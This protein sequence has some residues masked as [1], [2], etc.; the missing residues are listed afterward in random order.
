[1]GIE[2]R[3]HWLG[4]LRDWILDN[5]DRVLDTMQRETG[6]V[7]A[8]ATNEPAYLADLINF[9]GT[10][11]AEL[12]RRGG[13]PAALAAARLEEAAG[14]VPAAPGGRD[15]QP[16]ELPAGALARRRDPGAAGGRRGGDQAL[17][18]HAAGDRR[19]GRGLEARARRPRRLRR[20]PGDRRDRRRPGRQRRLRPV[21]R[22][23]PDRP[24]GDGAGGGDADPGQPRA[25]RQGPDDRPRRRRPRPRRQRRRLGRDVQLGPGLH[26]GRADLRRGARLRRASSP[27]SPP[28][29][30]SCARAPTTP[31]T[32]RTSAR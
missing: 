24:Q 15:H 5:Q 12:H 19:G 28:R 1:M 18:V 30:A 7:R 27:S 11:A 10:R 26:L 3:Y 22:L 13:D 25:R 4:K 2:G 17:G 29:S 14:P 32:P 21:H 31:A 20:R 9:Y 8:D 23:R 6:K 16:L